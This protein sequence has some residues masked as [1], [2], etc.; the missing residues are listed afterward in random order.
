MER[1]RRL[2]D[3]VESL[4]LS[5]VLSGGSPPTASTATGGD[6]G[7]GAPF[8][9][10]VV[11]VSNLVHGEVLPYSLCLLEGTAPSTASA[12]CVAVGDGPAVTFPAV[13]GLWKGA[14]DLAAGPN[15][16]TLTLP[17]AAGGA[18]SG[19]GDAGHGD[20]G[21][22]TL[23]LTYEAAAD[24]AGAPGTKSVRLVWLSSADGDGSFEV[25]PAP[26]A[27]WDVPHTATDGA[28]RLRTAGRLMQAATAEMMARQGLG[29]RTFRLA[30]GVTHLTLT[31]IPTAT[32]HRMSGHE[33]WSAVYAAASGCAR[34]D[35]YIDVAVMSFTVWDATA[36]KALAHTALGGGR[37]G[38]FGGSAV[39]S[40]PVATAAVAAT[41]TDT[42]PVNGA[43]CLDDGGRGRVWALASTTI[44]A[45][46]HELGHCLSLP[47]PCLAIAAD[48]GGGIMA[49]GF[50]HLNRLLAVTEAGHPLRSEA[51]EPFWDRGCAV[52]LR[53]HPWMAAVGRRPLR[54]VAGAGVGGGPAAA[55]ASATENGGDG[56]G[57]GNS[58]LV[59]R[60]LR[61]QRR[62][63]EATP[64]VP[65]PAHRT[66]GL[67]VPTPAPITLNDLGIGGA[68]PGHD[69]AVVVLAA[70]ADG[71]VPA[72]RGPHFTAG[73][74]GRLTI[75]VGRDSGG[76]RGHGVGLGHIG[77]YV[78][79]DNAGHEEWTADA[80]DAG[81][82]EEGGGGD[83]APSAVLLPSP[84]ALRS[85]LGAKASDR[86][87][88]AAIDTAGNM[89]SRD[90]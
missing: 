46:L 23:T 85:R 13:N 1:L 83:P 64:S 35:D 78:N 28:A 51:D 75:C 68:P 88:V 53:W 39:W 4:T 43:V 62:L 47:H 11:R 38:L 81:G 57:E 72:G 18:V 66:P 27:G 30:E 73:P 71:N 40:W 89:A 3:A 59:N 63:Y 60:A 20:D 5:D 74:E 49:R 76:S 61:A 48:R 82:P 55:N 79:G 52:R 26:H 7:G 50:D 56:S 24:G 77:Y 15:Q 36:R 42:R 67:P 10:G 25:P 65:M 17:H 32:A 12:V 33:L 58:G 87:S 45:A 41:F 54:G 29:R 80:D 84:A 37:L 6:S 16:L 2:R 90:L 22:T 86:L 21:A 14:V 19:S 8:T 70:A 9:T 31:D 34:R 69:G 44:G